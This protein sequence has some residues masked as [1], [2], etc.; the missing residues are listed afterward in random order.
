MGVPVF[1]S[2]AKPL[3]SW[4]TVAEIPANKV[5]SV[6]PG[7]VPE[8]AAVCAKR[9]PLEKLPSKRP[10]AKRKTNRELVLIVRLFPFMV[11]LSPYDAV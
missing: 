6:L 10:S 9:T 8:E 4:P 11:C 3:L 1:I 5:I 7:R 2:N